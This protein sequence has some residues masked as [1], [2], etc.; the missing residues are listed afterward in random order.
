[1][2]ARQKRSVSVYLWSW[3]H[4]LGKHTPGHVVSADEWVPVV[5]KAVAVPLVFCIHHPVLGISECWDSR[6]SMERQGI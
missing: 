6:T 3:F 2:T 5:L 4:K 1:M